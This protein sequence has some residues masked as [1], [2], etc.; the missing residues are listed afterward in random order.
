MYCKWHANDLSE[1]HGSVPKMKIVSQ[2]LGWSPIRRLYMSV[3][4]DDLEKDTELGNLSL[5]VLTNYIKI[6]GS[7]WPMTFQFTKD[8][9]SKELKLEESKKRNEQKSKVAQI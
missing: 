9:A 3:F 4:I 2:I 6:I 8:K 1:D 5:T 7:C